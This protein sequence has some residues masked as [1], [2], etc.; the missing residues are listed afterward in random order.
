MRK[1]VKTEFNYMLTRSSI[2]IKKGA[3]RKALKRAA[4]NTIPFSGLEKLKKR[5]Y[6]TVRLFDKSTDTSF[7]VKGICD[8]GLK[9]YWFQGAGP[10]HGKCASIPNK[11]ISSFDIKITHYA[12]EL[13]I[14][15]DT[16]IY[17]FLGTYT[18]KALR[19]VLKHRFRVWA[20]SKRK[21]PRQD[22]VEVLTWAYGWTL[23]HDGA[24]ATFSPMTF[25]I[26]RHGPLIAHHPELEQQKRYYRL[27]LDSLIMSGDLE[28]SKYGQFC[29][30][31]KALATLDN[32]E[33][34]DRRHKDNLRQQRRLGRLTLALVLIGAAQIIAPFLKE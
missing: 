13:E 1:S 25:L 26:H 23:D 27:I 16:A 4:P 24:N 17:F 15:Y 20:Y 28:K 30:A 22:R 11:Y 9:G 31:P 8:E 33:E 3:I 34:T 19:A 32:Y 12:H 5:D 10:E 21:L 2:S 7:L 29:L 18:F 6:Y 14:R